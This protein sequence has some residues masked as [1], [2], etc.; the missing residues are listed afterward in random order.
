MPSE[1]R[2]GHLTYDFYL[3][4]FHLMSDLIW[5]FCSYGATASVVLSW[6]NSRGQKQT[7]IKPIGRLPIMVRVRNASFT[8]PILHT[9]TILCYYI[10]LQSNKCWLAGKTPQGLIKAREDAT[11]PG[12]YFICNGNEKLVRMLVVP[13]RNTVC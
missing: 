12:G 1:C 5:L 3:L 7:I 11:E 8:H 10:F 2:Q 13:R 9:L 4:F 6:E